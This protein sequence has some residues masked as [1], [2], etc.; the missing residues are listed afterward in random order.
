MCDAWSQHACW[1]DQRRHSLTNSLRNEKI[2]GKNEGEFHTGGWMQCHLTQP[3]KTISKDE[4][5]N[6]KH[7]FS[8]WEEGKGGNTT[9]C[10]FTQQNTEF[11]LRFFLSSHLHLYSSPEF[12]SVHLQFTKWTLAPRRRRRTLLNHWT[13]SFYSKKGT[14][15]NRRI[16]KTTELSIER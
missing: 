9:T 10:G 13:P 16:K 12:T 1:N 14:M 3:M 11:T 8:K 7:T 15:R 2:A 6:N 5:N 4:K